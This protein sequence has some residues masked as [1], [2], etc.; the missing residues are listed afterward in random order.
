[1]NLSQLYMSAPYS[2]VDARLRGGEYRRP[3][4][5]RAL[6][7]GQFGGQDKGGRLAHR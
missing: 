4:L 3:A 6:E 1:M 5:L 7:V 2:M